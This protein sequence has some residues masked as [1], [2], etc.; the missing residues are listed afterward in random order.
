MLVAAL[1][2]AKPGEL[3]LVAAFGQGCDA[4]LFEVTDAI[5]ALPPRGGV[6]GAWRGASEETNYLR[7]LAFNDHIALERGMRAEA[8]KRHAADHA[9]PQPRHDH[10][11]RRRALPQAAARCSFRAGAIA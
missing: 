9:V 11:L 7:F 4:L 1:E 3:I 2:K 8:D 5:A 10:G 6:R